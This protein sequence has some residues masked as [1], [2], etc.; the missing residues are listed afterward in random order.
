MER[1]Q[2]SAARQRTEQELRQ[3]LLLGLGSDEAA[4]RR[5]LNALSTHLRGFVR[6]RLAS[7]PSDVEDLV[8][9]MLL[10][11]HDKRHTYRAGEPLT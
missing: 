11:I 1:T 6:R 5:F 3:W 7:R 8:Q 2:D 9:E 10:A 4:Y